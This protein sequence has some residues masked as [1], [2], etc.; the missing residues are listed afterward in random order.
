MADSNN[1]GGFSL[2]ELM[3]VVA[4]IGILAAL[5]VPQYMK[6][7]KRSRTSSGIEHVRMI[8]NAVMDW[9]ANPNMADG[10]VIN[11]PPFPVTT[12]GRDRKTFQ[13]HFPAEA[14][15]LADG[16]AYYTYPTVDLSSPKNP[17]V[18]AQARGGPADTSVYAAAIQAGGTSAVLAAPNS[19]L[20]GCRTNVEAVSSLY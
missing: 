11:Y 3:V 13:D 16:D 19:S 10:D 6:Y 7:V 17:V 8:C 2:I 5:A 1:Q 14:A 9:A 20:S 18:I 4:I 15:W 12:Q